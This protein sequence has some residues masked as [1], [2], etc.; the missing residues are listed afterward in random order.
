M[1]RSRRSTST[2]SGPRST[3]GWLPTVMREQTTAPRSAA[4]SLALKQN[5]GSSAAR[6]RRRNAVLANRPGPKARSCRASSAASSVGSSTRQGWNRWD[7]TGTLTDISATGGTEVITGPMRQRAGT[8]RGGLDRS[9]RPASRSPKARRALSS[10][11]SSRA[12][13]PHRGAISVVGCVEVLHD[14]QRATTLWR[15]AQSA[16]RPEALSPDAEQCV[17]IC[18]VEQN[19]LAP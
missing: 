10:A 13:H 1:P 16:D 12:K 7:G 11:A 6:S 17:S 3:P 8:G 19:A 2:A 4:P 18:P 15:G 5:A 9:C 14:R